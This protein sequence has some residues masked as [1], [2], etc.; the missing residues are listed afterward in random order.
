MIGLLV[1]LAGFVLVVVG[2]V[3]VLGVWVLVPAGVVVML[4]GMFAD[5]DRLKEPQRAK[6]SQSAP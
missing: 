5:L 4:V 2:L 6:R 1:I 3:L